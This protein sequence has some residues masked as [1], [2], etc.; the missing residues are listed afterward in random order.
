[1]TIEE[2]IV[3]KLRADPAVTALVAQRVYPDQA[4]MDAVL[5]YVVYEQSGQEHQRTLTGK[6]NLP[7]WRMRLD[8]YGQ[9]KASARAVLTALDSSLDSFQGDLEVG[10]IN[11]SGMFV[12]N[13]E[14]GAE[15][16]VHA[17]EFG[18]YTGG[19]DLTLHYSQYSLT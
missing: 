7:L 19:L 5:P 11:V 17:N 10:Q 1:M 15:V 9:T 16:P 3:G 4:P 13:M 2:A 6:V 12:D 14:S 18:E 8:A